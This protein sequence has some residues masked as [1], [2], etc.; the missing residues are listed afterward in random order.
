[1]GQKLLTVVLSEA[2]RTAYATLGLEDRRRMDSWL[3]HLRYWQ[4]D[5]YFR[6]YARP[7][8][9]DPAVLVFEM[10]HED[11]MFAFTVGAEHVTV[12]SIFRK[13]AVHK[14]QGASVRAAS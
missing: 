9:G 8:A 11:L 3:F 14:F 2:A 12:V 1:M 13:E 4:Q 7:L 6:E 10:P 5:A